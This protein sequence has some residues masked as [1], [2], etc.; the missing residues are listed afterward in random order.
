VLEA[1]ACG[2]P[3]LA[4]DA[5]R[6]RDVRRRRPPRRAGRLNRHPDLLATAPSAT[7]ACGGAGRAA[8]FTW[9]GRRGGRRDR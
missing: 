6:C 1:M 9:T 8:A 7:A 3:V 5:A 2:T 4:A